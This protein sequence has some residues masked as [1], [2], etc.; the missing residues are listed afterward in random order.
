MNVNF[1]FLSFFAGV[2]E[3]EA[4]GLVGILPLRGS[5]S[6]ALGRE[7]SASRNFL[8]INPAKRDFLLIKL[9]FAKEKFIGLVGIRTRGLPRS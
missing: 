7:P 8:Y 6:L 5:L 9:F 3:G 4:I 1:F 2:P